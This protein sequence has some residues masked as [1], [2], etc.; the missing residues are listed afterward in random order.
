MAELAALLASYSKRCAAMP[1]VVANMS[2]PYTAQADAWQAWLIGSLFSG[3]CAHFEISP[4]MH[5]HHF[6][7][8]Q[9]A[10]HICMQLLPSSRQ[11]EHLGLVQLA[12]EATTR[13]PG[14]H[15]DAA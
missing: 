1:F 4:N 12:C 11:A 8:K 9:Q 15:V 14:V 6:L 10:P 5:T 3:F 2:V 7:H 13:R